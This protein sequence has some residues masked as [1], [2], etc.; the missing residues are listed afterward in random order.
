MKNQVKYILFIFAFFTFSQ[1]LSAATENEQSVRIGIE[2][3]TVL[4]ER[5]AASQNTS[6][7]FFIENLGAETLRVSKIELSIYDQRGDLQLR[8]FLTAAGLRHGDY[9]IVKIAPKSLAFIFNP[10]E[11]F[12][13]E[14]ALATL[15]YDFFIESE[16]G[17]KTFSSSVTV[18]PKVFNP[19]T[20]LTI[21]LKGRILVHDGHNVYSHHRRFNLAHPYLKEIN[22]THN[23]TRYASDLCIVNEK[24]DLRRNVSDANTD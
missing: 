8:K 12:S 23:F 1:N 15:R 24:G 2:P 17:S 21:P 16:N 5:T 6:F 10:F 22:V 18:E 19:K 20:M 14:V 9:E 13:P 11:N 7:D 4:I 3:K